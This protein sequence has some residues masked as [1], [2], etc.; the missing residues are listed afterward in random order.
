MHVLGI[1][2]SMCGDSETVYTLLKVTFLDKRKKQFIFKILENIYKNWNT[3]DKNRVSV[4]F[5]I[6]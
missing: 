6:T 4:N 1:A 2:A 5:Q 3:F